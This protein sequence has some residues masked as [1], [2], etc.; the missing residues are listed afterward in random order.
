MREKYI[1]IS[2]LKAGDIFCY[3]NA[4]YEAVMKNTWPTACKYIND[5]MTPIPECL[6]CDFSNYTK[7]EI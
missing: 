5:D 4:I 2:R 1:K 3:R 6:Y 7:V